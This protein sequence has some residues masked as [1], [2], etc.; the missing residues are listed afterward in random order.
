MEFMIYIYILYA[1]YITTAADHLTGPGVAM[2][3]WPCKELGELEKLAPRLSEY[4]ELYQ[5]KVDG[6]M[7]TASH[8]IGF[9]EETMVYIPKSDKIRG[10]HGC[11]SKIREIFRNWDF[12]NRTWPQ[13]S[14]FS[15]CQ[16]QEAAEGQA[17][18][19]LSKAL[20]G[21]QVQRLSE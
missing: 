9:A 13:F 18:E 12:A 21:A 6:K 20:E 3:R 4:L 17:E 14:G 8:G 10:T 7:G 5:L 11:N 15:H 1:A 19:D 2:T 16:A